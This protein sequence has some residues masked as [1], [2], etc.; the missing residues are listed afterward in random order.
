MVPIKNS[1]LWRRIDHALS[2]HDVDCRIWRMDDAHDK[3][4]DRRQKP[5]DNAATI[6]FEP[7]HA[8]KSSTKSAASPG[9]RLRTD[10]LSDDE[11][12]FPIGAGR[13]ESTHRK[14]RFWLAA[15]RRVRELF[16]GLRLRI[17]QLG[18]GILP[19]PWLE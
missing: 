12:T 14:R 17:G 18:T 4:N 9:R 11:G 7:F 19:R 1:D 13:G 5:T 6:R 10:L 15:L 8:Q 16:S 3:P 2:I